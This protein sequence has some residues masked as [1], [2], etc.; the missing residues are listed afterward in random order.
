MRDEFTLDVKRIVANRVNS[1]CS[2][3]DC[4]A[5]T[6]GPNSDPSKALNIGVAAHIS[7]ASPGGPRYR[8]MS[9]ELRSHAS[10]AIWLCQNC[11]KLID[12]DPLHYTEEIL[13][14]WK[15][16]AES[17][18]R[19]SL[20]KTVSSPTADDTFPSPKFTLHTLSPSSVAP[21]SAVALDLNVF[22]SSEAI[23]QQSYLFA[24]LIAFENRVVKA[25]DAEVNDV[26]AEIIFKSPGGM[27]LSRIASACWVNHPHAEISFPL[28][29]PRFLFVGGWEIVNKKFV[30]DIQ[31]FEFS[32]SLNRPVEKK[33]S[34]YGYPHD[35]ILEVTLTPGSFHEGSQKFSFSFR[36]MNRGLYS[37]RPISGR[38]L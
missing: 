26:W 15:S 27:E 6:T 35:L 36:I 14:G 20:G 5:T 10:N 37:I 1:F 21:H 23:S 29:T 2:N 24:A 33:P 16:T 22:K 38:T 25:G 17:D 31:L 19:K 28:N 8:P 30:S 13:R 7:A 18:A 34:F 32:R 4:R 11:A 3:P 12:N 9:K